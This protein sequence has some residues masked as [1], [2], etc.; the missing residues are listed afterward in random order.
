MYLKGGY[1]VDI[2][3]PFEATQSVHIDTPKYHLN[4]YLITALFA[5]GVNK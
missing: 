3:R 2:K 1:C 4:C 5:H